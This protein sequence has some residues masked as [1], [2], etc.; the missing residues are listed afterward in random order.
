[1]PVFLAILTFV[2]NPLFA[3]PIKN[4]NYLS[5]DSGKIVYLVIQ[6]DQGLAD[7]MSSFESQKP[8]L[9]LHTLA[10]YNISR[11]NESNSQIYTLLRS[12]TK[13]LKEFYVTRASKPD[14]GFTSTNLRT[15]L[16]LLELGNLEV[17]RWENQRDLDL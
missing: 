12:Q 5:D 6:G 4:V 8:N 2:I 1:M 9:A 11:S 17:L 14:S 15:I 13:H 10:L 7:F 16:Q 3:Q